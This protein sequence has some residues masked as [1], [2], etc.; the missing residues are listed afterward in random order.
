MDTRLLQAFIMLAETKNYR[1][2]ALKL[3]V[4]QPALTKQIQTLESE[5][6]LTLFVRSRRGTLLTV[7]GK[8]LIARATLIVKQVKELKDFSRDLAKG[9]AGNLV[10][11]FG[12]S[13]IRIAPEMVA[14]FHQRYPDVSINLEDIPSSIQ[15]EKLLEGSLQ[16]AF[17]SMPTDPPLIGLVL[18][19][20]SLVLAAPLNKLPSFETQLKHSYKALGA[21]PM[22]SLVR[23]R[24][25][26][27]NQQI[28][29]FLAFNEVHPDIQQQARDLHTLL[30]LVS[31]GVGIALVPESAARLAL[32]GVGIIPL[33]GP[34]TSWDVGLI[35]D[36][37]FDDPVRIYLLRW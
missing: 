21:Y 24:G 17:M 26:G 23:E 37:F 13:G 29:R 3:F 18:R 6:R 11:G 22:L 12:M 2:A 28:D 8:Q 19:Q 34:Y 27:L 31:A 36:P 16:L 4:T 25:P 15:V 30:A 10:M 14:Q 1:E 5:L 35:W 7:A 9:K 32:S 33:C 20:E